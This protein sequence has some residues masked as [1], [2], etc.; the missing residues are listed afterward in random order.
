MKFSV[1]RSSNIYETFSPLYKVLKFLGIITFQLD[2]S[3]GKVSVK[4]FDL[5]WMLVWWIFCSWM[6]VF[7]VKLGAREQMENSIILLTG[8]HW[9][10][11]LQL[12]SVFYIQAVGLVKRKRIEKLFRIIS[13]IDTMVNIFYFV[14]IGTKRKFDSRTSP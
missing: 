4:C 2:L 1:V 3:T 11:L 5:L 6:I 8:W 12:M 13:E 9:N 10:L 7:N 14:R